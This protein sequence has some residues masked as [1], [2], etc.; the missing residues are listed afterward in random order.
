MLTS[1]IIIAFIIYI[2]IKNNLNGKQRKITPRSL[3]ILPLLLIYYIYITI[4]TM[5]SVSIFSLSIYAFA[6][7]IGTLIGIYRSS[8]YSFTHANGEVFYSKHIFDSVALIALLIFD[9][10]LRLIFQKY[11]FSLFNVINL[12]L[13]LLAA[14]SMIT[15]RVIMFIKYNNKKGTI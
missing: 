12:A 10:L 3:V 1:I 14:S 6:I 2:S 13:I 9:T 11:D 15:R 4:E 5:H 7:I 8:L